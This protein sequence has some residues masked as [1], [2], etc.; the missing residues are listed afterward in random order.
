VGPNFNTIACGNLLEALKYEKRI[1]TAYTGF[2][3]WFLDGRGW[4][5]LAQGTPLFWAVPYQDLQVRLLPIY[6]TGSGAGTAE[7]S[8][9]PKG[10][11]GW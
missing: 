3:Q 11:Y 1:E 6:S 2:A 7:N 8:A 5:D 4:G 9:A 10:T